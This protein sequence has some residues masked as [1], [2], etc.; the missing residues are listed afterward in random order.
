MATLLLT[1]AGSALGEFVAGP[2]G[3]AIG[4]AAGAL[5]GALLQPGVSQQ[6]R[7]HVGPRLTKIAGVLF[8][9]TWHHYL[10]RAR[11]AFV[12][13]RR[14]KTS[15]FWRMTNELPFLAAIVMVMAV[16]TEFGHP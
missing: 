15:K 12:A 7:L 1:A 5:G 4:Q 14:D 2:I 10:G 6:T 8:L 3:A 13:G 9:T 16:T 11:K